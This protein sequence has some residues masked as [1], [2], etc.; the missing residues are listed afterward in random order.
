M[1]LV[2]QTP[3]GTLTIG[4]TTVQT[5]E[6]E[7]GPLLQSHYEEVAKHRDLMMLRPR[8]DVYKQMQ[9]C[10]GLFVL[11]ASIGGTLVGYSANFV[12]QHLHYAGLTYAQND[13]L[14]VLPEHR[15]TSV[16]IKLIRATER[17]A[18]DRGVQLMLW[19]A[20]QGTKL[21]ALLSGSDRYSVQ[22]IVYGRRL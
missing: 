16:G 3:A 20:K 1:G 15:S 4:L 6:R 7:G 9:D 8:W 10:G 18:K 2:E 17:E 21:D 22:D 11:H 12:A 14:F 13:V 19:H 5:I